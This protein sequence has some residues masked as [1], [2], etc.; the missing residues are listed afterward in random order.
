MMNLS[1][2]AITPSPRA[3]RGPERR[4]HVR[5]EDPFPARVQGIDADGNAFD[6]EVKIDDVSA[7]GLHM[8][9]PHCVPVGAKLSTTISF[10]TVTMA[11]SRA[12]R[13][14]IHG[15]VLRTDCR[16][17]GTCAVAIEF[18]HHLFL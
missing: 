2:K 14:A 12:P 3:Y 10:T 6:L 11:R 8:G 16:T 18:E 9:L 17:E 7:G 13:L 1:E 4:R 15:T 5:L